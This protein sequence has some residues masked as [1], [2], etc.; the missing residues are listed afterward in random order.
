M[1]IHR[2]IPC[3]N[4]CGL[5]KSVWWMISVNITLLSCHLLSLKGP[6]RSAHEGS[7]LH[8][9]CKHSQWQVTA[10][11]ESLYLGNFTLT[12]GSKAV[13][14]R[15][16]QLSWDLCNLRSSC[17]Q[18]N[19][20]KREGD[21]A[22]MACGRNRWGQSFITKAGWDCYSNPLPSLPTALV[23]VSP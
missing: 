23:E 8:C 2:G 16:Q 14:L 7:V 15:K 10:F 9:A 20:G 12:E 4:P 19:G 1:R 17:P 6:I 11:Y 21:G 22:A 5:F 13:S 3:V 18:Q